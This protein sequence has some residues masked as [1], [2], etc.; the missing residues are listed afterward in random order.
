MP[1]WVRSH[2][3][4]SFFSHFFTF[5]CLFCFFFAISGC[6]NCMYFEYFSDSGPSYVWS[7]ALHNAAKHSIFFF[8]FLLF[9]YFCEFIVSTIRFYNSKKRTSLRI[10]GFCL[11]LDYFVIFPLDGVNAQSLSIF[12]QLP[13]CVSSGKKTWIK[14]ERMLISFYWKRNMFGMSNKSPNALLLE[15]MWML[16]WAAQGCCCCCILHARHLQLLSSLSRSMEFLALHAWKRQQVLAGLQMTS[17]QK[18]NWWKIAFYTLTFHKLK[19]KARAEIN[20]FWL[21]NLETHASAGNVS[22]KIFEAVFS[23]CALLI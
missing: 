10:C 1:F 7:K 15:P 17:R 21:N 9:V 2:F 11:C 3:L 8:F 19:Y 12:I 22:R 5:V 14:H 18:I 4:H 6:F 16:L 23:E 20:H 13:G